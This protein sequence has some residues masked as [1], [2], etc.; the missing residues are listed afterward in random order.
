V[1]KEFAFLSLTLAVLQPVSFCR[2][3]CKKQTNSWKSVLLD[4]IWLYCRQIIL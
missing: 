1:K 4:T 2:G 3:S